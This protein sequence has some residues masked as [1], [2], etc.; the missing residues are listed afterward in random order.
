MICIVRNN[1]GRHAHTCARIKYDVYLI[2]LDLYLSLAFFG[3][4][5][6]IGGVSNM[7]DQPKR[8]GRPKKQVC[9]VLPISKIHA[10]WDANDE[11]RDRLRAGGHLLAEGKGEDIKQVVT[12]IGVL[13]PFVT[14]MSLTMTR[15]MPLVD[16]LRDELEA[17]YMKAKRGQTAED[18]PDIIGLSWRINKLLG[19][20]KMKVRRKEVSNVPCS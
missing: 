8:Q 7:E 10:E 12:N 9:E 3:S 2:D 19:F 16:Q 6:S 18:S 4:T 14:R 1:I 11:I 17:V 15:P 20:I 5:S 13:Q